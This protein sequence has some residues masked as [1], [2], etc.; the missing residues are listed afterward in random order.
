MGVAELRDVGG[1]GLR[2][3]EIYRMRSKRR[4]SSQVSGS[5][6][7]RRVDEHAAK[8]IAF[9]VDTGQAAE[10]AHFIYAGQLFGG[11]AHQGDVVYAV[12]ARLARRH[13]PR[14]LLI[15][16]A[17]TLRTRVASGRG[18]VA[19]AA[20]QLQQ[21]ILAFTER[22]MAQFSIFWFTS[23]LGWVKAPSGWR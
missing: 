16:V 2:L 15:S 18:E 9:Q 21:V 22:F 8:V 13:S 5:M 4:V 17:S 7:A 23:P 10:R 14:T 1:Q 6:P 12:V 11:Q 19:V 3:Q 20:I